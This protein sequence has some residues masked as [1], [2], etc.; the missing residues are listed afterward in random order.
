MRNLNLK[1]TKKNLEAAPAS[2]L[3][4]AGFSQTHDIQMV[5]YRC[6]CFIKLIFLGEKWG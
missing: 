2:S 6:I 3:Y 1:G 5:F 4:M